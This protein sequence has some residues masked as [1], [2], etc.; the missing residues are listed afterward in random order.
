MNANSTIMYLKGIINE[1]KKHLNENS[2]YIKSLNIDR[3]EAIETAIEAM[4][5]KELEE[6]GLLA[7]KP[8]N[9]GDVVWVITK[10]AEYNHKQYEVIKCTVSKMDFMQNGIDIKFSCRGHYKNGDYYNGNFR[11]TSINKTVFLTEEKAIAEF[12]KNYR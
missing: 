1:Y 6:K 9:R 2:D 8:C 11:N 7:V 3:I 5:Y 4:K 12:E 10:G